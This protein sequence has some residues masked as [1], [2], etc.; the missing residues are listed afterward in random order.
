MQSRLKIHFQNRIMQTHLKLDLPTS[1]DNSNK[2]NANAQQAWSAIG[3]LVELFE[4]VFSTVSQLAFVV[5]LAKD[6]KGG[7]RLAFLCLVSPI[8]VLFSK[9]ELWSRVFGIYASNKHYLRA[10]AFFNIATNAEYKQ[11]VMVNGAEEYITEEFGKA[12]DALGNVS[13]D[14]AFRLF[15]RTR[16]PVPVIL[17][18]FFRDLP[19]ITY[20]IDCIL[21][22]EYFSVASLA[23]LQQTSESLRWTFY[24][25]KSQKATMAEDLSYIK[26]LYE[27]VSIPN[28]IES[29]DLSYPLDE[30]AEKQVQRGMSIELRDVTFAYPGADSRNVLE[31]ISTSIPASSLVVIVG[32]NGSGKSS[33]VKLLT[34]LHRPRSGD[35]LI[36]S[37]PISAY[38]TTDLRR[39]TALLTQDHSVF[40]L[41]IAENIGLGDPANATD[42]TRV[43][44]AAKMGGASGFIAKLARKWDEVLFPI[45]TSYASQ[46]PMRPGDLRDV[47]LRVEKQS[48]ISGGEKQRLVASRTFMR[49]MSG[50]IKLL[51]VDE[52][53]SAMD[54]QGEFELFERLRGMR[55][56]KTTVFVT[57][58]FGH[59][60]KHADLI[61]CMKEGKLV[62]SGTHVEL[63]AR[64]GEYFSLYNIQ[65]QAFTETP[66]EKNPS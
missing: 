5:D 25:L 26:A 24:R 19:L 37:H 41:N 8:Y 28:T 1:Q 60:T 2:F 42:R 46:Y 31:N 36:D 32:A 57:H 9:R 65:A 55:E 35:I 45:T 16:T 29:G 39:A 22:P 3:H 61:L 23:M 47:M 58:R 10:K 12:E 54:P 6:H 50:N 51:V 21:H 27:G 38:S 66:L 15:S 64:N 53:T 4:V 30:S 17:A 11:E 44:E 52:P 18:D 20:A 34:N 56:G 63:M 13:D 59:L 40:P 7:I 48:D 49:I 43:E 14:Y 62:E 33:L